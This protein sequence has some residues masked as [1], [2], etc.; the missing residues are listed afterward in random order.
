M[1]ERVARSALI[2]RGIS[3]RCLDALTERIA[4]GAVLT[5]GIDTDAVE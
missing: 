1:A 2:S 5:I 3:H 4:D